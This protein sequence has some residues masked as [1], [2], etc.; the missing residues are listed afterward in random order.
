M[1]P[2]ITIKPGIS[3]VTGREAELNTTGARL[4]N[5]SRV[6]AM[7]DIGGQ[8]M[9][10]SWGSGF[11]NFQIWPLSN[12]FRKDILINDTFHFELFKMST[13]G[14]TPS[15]VDLELKL[16]AEEFQIVTDK[17]VSEKSKM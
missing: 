7:N 8:G 3:L 9:D 17:K 1:P 10:G 12:N 2:D 5:L 13:K 16:E 4:G 11:L 6:N 14:M 15:E